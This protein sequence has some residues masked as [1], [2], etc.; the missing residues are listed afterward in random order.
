MQY[1]ITELKNKTSIKHVGKFDKFL[2]LRTLLNNYIIC[3]I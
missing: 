3:A 1:E 2:G